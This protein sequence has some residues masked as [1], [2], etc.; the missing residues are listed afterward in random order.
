M[1]L[2]LVRPWMGHAS[3]PSVNLFMATVEI[4]VIEKVKCTGFSQIQFRGQ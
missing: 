2:G 4:A 1:Y 3:L